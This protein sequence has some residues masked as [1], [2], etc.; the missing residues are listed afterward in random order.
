MM[1]P[2]QGLPLTASLQL[3]TGRP[4]RLSLSQDTLS[5]LLEQVQGQGALNL[6]ITSLMGS[7]SPLQGQVSVLPAPG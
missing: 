1:T 7:N 3:A 5:A 2:M 4:P 6:S